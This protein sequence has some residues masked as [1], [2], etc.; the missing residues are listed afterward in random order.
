MLLNRAVN[1]SPIKSIQR[2]VG[3]LSNSVEV[4][5]VI[6]AVDMS[7]SVVNFCG[8]S[9]G[10]VTTG[11]WQGESVRMF[12]QSASTLRVARAGSN[13]VASNFSWEVVEY[14]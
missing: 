1:P 7:K 11:S 5:V 13:N 12:L 6:A 3:S 10:S 4:D 2:G 8:V 9:S 14:V